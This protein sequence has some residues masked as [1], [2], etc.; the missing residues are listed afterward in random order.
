MS[1]TQTKKCV[2]CG[3]PAE[4]WSGYVEKLSGETVDAGW[5]SRRCANKWVGR[6]GEFKARAHGE[7]AIGI[8]TA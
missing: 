5:C 8:L 6:V 2:R 7:E 1:E 4:M 3:K